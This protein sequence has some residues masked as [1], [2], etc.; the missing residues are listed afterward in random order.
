M[1][2]VPKFSIREEVSRLTKVKAHCEQEGCYFAEF[3]ATDDEGGQIT[4]ERTFW[5]TVQAHVANTAHTVT[6]EVTK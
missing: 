2:Q 1:S 3:D 4:G 6:I 5:A